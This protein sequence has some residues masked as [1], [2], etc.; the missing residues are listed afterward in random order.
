MYIWRD[1]ETLAFIATFPW[2]KTGALTAA[3]R[4]RNCLVEEIWAQR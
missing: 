4:T 2:V 3:S 1:K